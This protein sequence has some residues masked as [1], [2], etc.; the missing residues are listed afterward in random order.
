MA[1]ASV[2]R[3]VGLLSLLPLGASGSALRSQGLAEVERSLVQPEYDDG[4]RLHAA[5]SDIK[6]HLTGTKVSE[7]GHFLTSSELENV[8]AVSCLEAKQINPAV[9]CDNA[10]VSLTAT[11]ES[12]YQ[13]PW[14]TGQTDTGLT[15][16]NYPSYEDA[17]CHSQ[18]EYLCDFSEELEEKEQADV[19][20]LLKQK[21][22]DTPVQCGKLLDDTVDRRHYQPFYLGVAVIKDWPTE[23]S[24]PDSLQQLGQIIGAQWNMG[25]LFVGSTIP[26]VQCPN[27]G[28]LLILTK[29]RQAY[30]STESCEFICRDRGGPEVVTAV[31]SALDTEGPNAAVQAGIKTVYNILGRP[32]AAS[33][34]SSSVAR[35]SSISSTSDDTTAEEHT[36]KSIYAARGGESNSSISVMGQRLIFTVAALLLV[37]SLYI[38]AMVCANAPGLEKRLRR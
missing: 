2:V 6:Q 18:G 10:T 23:A 20:L 25:Q 11:A 7:E 22:E 32:G 27:T 9:V 1:S 17:V 19:A 34:S 12:G 33:L 37:A 5:V 4:A 38:G 30:L 28:M 29:N 35:S 15:A 16:G 36:P 21:R 26:Q 13:S 8:T 24:G 14:K 3:A 31:L